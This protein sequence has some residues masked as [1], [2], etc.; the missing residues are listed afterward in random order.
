MK[1]TKE[2]LQSLIQS[3]DSW[4]DLAQKVGTRPGNCRQNFKD[5]IEKY[6]IDISHFVNKKNYTIRTHDNTFC[7]DS[8]SSRCVARKKILE[9]NLIPYVCDICKCTNQWQGKTMPLI[10][11]HIN[12]IPNDH[13]LEN[14]RFLCS[15]CDSIQDTYKNKNTRID[16]E[17]KKKIN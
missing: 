7:I 3:S 11:D 1:Y 13:R 14:L 8:S 5:K 17:R 2:Y 4:D 9:G 12:G 6:G 10:L 16:R 15:N